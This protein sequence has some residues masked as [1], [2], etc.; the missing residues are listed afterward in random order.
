MNFILDILKS[1]LANVL[2]KPIKFLFSFG[3]KA[4]FILIPVLI[5]IA[6]LGDMAGLF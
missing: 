1:V 6:Y 5:F 4:F 3:F 2:T